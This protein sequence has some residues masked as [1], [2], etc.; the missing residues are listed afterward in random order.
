MAKAFLQTST[1][2]LIAKRFRG[3]INIQKP[4]KPHFEKQLLL[5]LSKPFFGPRK[6]TLPEISLCEKGKKEWA[7]IEIDNPFERILARECLEWFNTSKMVVFIHVNSISMEEKTPV[8]AALKKNNMHLR[9]YGKKIVKMAT[10]GT[11]YEAVNHLFTSHQNVIFG[12]PENSAK[13][14]NILKKA[15]QLIV[16]GGIIQ[17]KLLS[18]NELVEFSKL[19]NLEVARS[20]LCS[21][22][23][24]AGSSIVGQLN[25]SQQ[26]LVGHL[27]KHVEIQNSSKADSSPS[28]DNAEDSPAS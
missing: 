14:F 20:Q 3:K 7:K 8:Y 15:P 13:M 19:P 24:S 23:Q 27:E 16:M 11:R 10:T 25:Q 17:D 1:P 2:F 22:L 18:K 26:M 5:D 9:T 4:R 6:N 28:Q 12:Q 21:I